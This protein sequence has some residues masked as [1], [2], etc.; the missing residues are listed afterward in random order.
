MTEWVMSISLALLDSVI[1]IRNRIQ[2]PTCTA[3]GLRCS[4]NCK[5]LSFSQST[6]LIR[7]HLRPACNCF[8]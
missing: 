7:V 6:L 3:W 1:P 5:V 2:D 4:P 8:I